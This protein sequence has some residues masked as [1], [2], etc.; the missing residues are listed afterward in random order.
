MDILT[1][2]FICVVMP[3]AIVWLVM[4]TKQNETNKTAEI[5]IKAIES[6]NPIDQDSWIY[7]IVPTLDTNKQSALRSEAK[8]VRE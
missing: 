4:R 8:T 3:V 6:G 2:I 7:Y 1:P 5:I